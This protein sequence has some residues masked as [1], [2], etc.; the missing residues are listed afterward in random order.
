MFYILGNG[1]I[2]GVSGYSSSSSNSEENN[3]NTSTKINSNA[4]S[5]RAMTRFLSS[6]YKTISA[7][8]ADPVVSSNDSVNSTLNKR[9]DDL[10]NVI[11]SLSEKQ[12][13]EAT[14]LQALSNSTRRPVE[15]GGAR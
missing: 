14:M 6:R 3:S 13:M 8:G 2:Q 7:G 5:A 12:D 10:I 9:F 11:T 4:Q 15:F 1:A